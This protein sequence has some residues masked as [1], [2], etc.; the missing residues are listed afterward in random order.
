MVYLS[1]VGQA[2]VLFHENEGQQ[3]PKDQTL[4]TELDIF[5]RRIDMVEKRVDRLE[6]R[7]D[8][9]QQALQSDIRELRN[10]LGNRLGNIE[11]AIRETTVTALRSWPPSA[12]WLLGVAAL[13]GGGISWL[14][15]RFGR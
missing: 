5:D 3:A 11:S 8:T 4:V 10:E 7:L 6:Q 15:I 2:N 9:V 12:V 1:S 13:I 14:L